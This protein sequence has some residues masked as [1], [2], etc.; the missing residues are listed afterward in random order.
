MFSL[1]Q[2]SD[3]LGP[4]TSYHAVPNQADPEIQA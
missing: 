2:L 4:T 3:T 1:R